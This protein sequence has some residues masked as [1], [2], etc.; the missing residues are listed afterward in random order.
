LTELS[1]S[2]TIAE[3]RAF[4]FNPGG[5][6]ALT[7]YVAVSLVVALLVLLV[8]GLPEGSVHGSDT[9]FLVLGTRA[10]VQCV[11]AH[12]FVNCGHEDGGTHSAVYPYPL[13]QYVPAAFLTLFPL[14]NYNIVGILAGLNFGA[15]VVMLLL[16]M[17]AGR[18]WQHGAGTPLLILAVTVSPLWFYATSGFSEM[19]AAC[20]IVALV[21]AARAGAAVPLAVLSFC[22]VLGKETIAPF[23]LIMG[24]LVLP[25]DPG[26]AVPRARHL[27][28]L[29]GGVLTGM[30][31]NAAFN[32]FRFGTARNLTYLIPAFRVPNLETRVNF[33]AALLFSPSGGVLVYAPVIGFMS[34][35]LIALAVRNL[36]HAGHRA[37]VAGSLL[38]V[39]AGLSYLAVL[40]NWFSPFGW[41]AWGPRLCVP[42]LPAFAVAALYVGGD[43]L[44]RLAAKLLEPVVGLVAAMLLTV[45]AG[46]PQFGMPWS[47]DSVVPYLVDPSPPCDVPADAIFTD[48]DGY[49]E[50]AKHQYWRLSPS[51]PRAAVDNNT[52]EA[53]ANEVMLSVCSC[54]LILLLRRRLLARPRSPRPV[55]LP[56]S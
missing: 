13:L 11:K 37:F 41:Y 40:S 25:R 5:I 6:P 32:V 7:L 29:A 15:F 53:R 23:V 3:R 38:L 56:T 21:V 10:A 14:S 51:L 36:T 46:L 31:T 9:D 48:P 52:I 18:S 33:F 4:R 55:N 54:A 8:R 2:R 47:F 30:L 1:P 19:T 49:Y 16:V 34:L 27:M 44:A 43:Q 26:R 45:G 17:R 50:C 12:V 20:L 24:V 42:L 39:G 35:M 28:P 22:A